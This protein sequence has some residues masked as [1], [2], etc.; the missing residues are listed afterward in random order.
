MMPRKA[1]RD[2]AH[3]A[4]SAIHGMDYLMTWNCAHIANA[5][6]SKTIQAICVQHGF[7]CPV[8]CIPE[9]LLEA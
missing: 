6:M 8:I 5:M 4:I 9:E 7:T 1:A 3:I 2:A